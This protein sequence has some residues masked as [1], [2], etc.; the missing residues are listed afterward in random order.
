MSKKHNISFL[1]DEWKIIEPEFNF[2]ILPQSES[3]FSLSNGYIGIRGNYEENQP[4]FRRGS[5]ING[6]YE[7]GPINYGEKY[8]GYIDNHQSI[9]N[10]T[11][12]KVIELL[13]DNEPFNLSTGKIHKYRRELDMLKGILYRYIIWESP[14]GNKVELHVKR[15]VSLTEKHLCAISYKIKSLNSNINIKI[16]SKIEGNVFDKIIKKDPRVGSN[17]KRKVLKIIDKN[18]SDTFGYIHSITNKTKLSVL[19]AMENI[20]NTEIE[21][22]INHIVTDNTVNLQIDIN[23]NLNQEV[24]LV[25]Y[26]T[27]FSSEI[28]FKLNLLEEAKKLLNHYKNICFDELLLLQENYL[29]EFWTK[30]D[31]KIENDLPVQ[32]SIRFNLFQLI[33]AAKFSDGKSLGAKGLTGEGYNGHYFWDTEIYIMPFFIYNYPDIAKSLLFYRYSILD[34]ARERANQMSHCGALYPWRTINGEEASEYYPGGTAQYHI[35]AD[36]IY[37][38]KKYIDINNDIDFLKNYGA[39]MLFETARLWIGLGHY[40]KEKKGRFCINAVTGPDEYTAIVN[41][42]CYTNLMAKYHLEYAV[43]I[44]KFLKEN[45]I[46]DFESIVK[47]IDLKESEVEEWKKASLLMYIPYDRKNEIYLQDDAFLNRPKLD[48]QKIP[49]N[50]FPLLLYFHPLVIYRHQ[51][52]KQP[53]VVMALFLLGNRFSVSEKRK[54]FDFYD[55]LTTGDS[56][57]SPCIQSIISAELNNIKKS[58]EYFMKTS[59]IDLD[60]NYGNTDDGLHLAAIGGT[61]LSLVYGFAGMRDYNGVISFKPQLPD[62]WQRLKFNLLINRN[63]INIDIYK[64]KIIYTLLEGSE[65]D[66]FHE[67]QKINLKKGIKEVISLLPKLEAVIFDLDGVITDTSRYHYKA[68]KI[69]A[70]EEGLIFDELMN[71]YLK[72]ISRMESLEIILKN[73]KIILDYD[74]KKKLCERKNNYYK[75]LIKEIT[76]ENILPNILHFLNDL[77][78]ENIKIALASAS[79]NAKDIVSRLELRSYFDFIADPSNIKNGK[80]NPDIFYLAADKLK[81]SN[82]NC[83]GIEDAQAGVDAIKSAGMYAVGIGKNL[84]FADLLL[85][86]SNNLTLKKL[87]T[88]FKGQLLA[89]IEELEVIL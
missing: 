28:G 52:L 63:L 73:N 69:L 65:I 68:W 4:L 44:V 88:E 77:K 43:N 1:L 15:M 10:I 18:I 66:I 59:R 80:P 48:L 75:E 55:P 27:Y 9:V 17:L 79:K 29:K 39:E 11:D 24:E 25:K 87:K 13:V 35:N 71:Q 82:K 40:V 89:N 19:C 67:N 81:V 26:F 83:I 49:P 2:H 22:N 72:G 74:K 37:A 54:N 14:S 42:N 3:I 20:I 34:K 53:D 84:K 8:H 33:Q 60:N 41:N 6:F 16:N 78:K 46:N 32:Q 61:W 30:S 85:T 36:V 45:Y 38:V 58:Y 31:I 64:D 57:L 7:S 56:S 21:Y 5:Y 70:D 51:V 23:T 86:N 50:N 62:K 12:G 76:P 47:K